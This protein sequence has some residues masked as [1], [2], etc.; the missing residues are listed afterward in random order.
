MNEGVCRLRRGD[1]LWMQW[2][3]ASRS[4][5]G[6]EGK[7]RWWEREISGRVV[8][9]LGCRTEGGVGSVA[10]GAWVRKS[11]CLDQPDS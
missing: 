11:L 6:Q 10:L 8:C 3:R 1:Q 2:V 9:W 7:L 5:W 4:Y